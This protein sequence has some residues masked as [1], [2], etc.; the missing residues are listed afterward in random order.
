MS[1]DANQ[2]YEVHTTSYDPYMVVTGSGYTPV[3][4]SNVFMYS[5][6][7]SNNRK[8]RLLQDSQG[9]WR[10]QNLANGLYMT[11]G[12]STPANGVNVRQWTS[13]T[14]AIQYWSITEL[15]TVR[16]E[17]LSGCPVVEI[18]SYATSDAHTWMLDIESAMVSDNSNV[19]IARYSSTSKTQEF[20]LVPVPP[21]DNGYPTP[22]SVGWRRGGATGVPYATQGGN[23]ATNMCVGWLCPSTWIPSDSLGYERRVRVRRMDGTTSTWGAWGEWEAWS[24]VDPAMYEQYCYDTSAIDASFTYPTHKAVE[25]QAEVRAVAN[26]KHGPVAA[27]TMRAIYDPTATLT[28]GGATRGGL[29]VNVA[30][31]YTPATYTI[32]SLVVDGSEILGKATSI[33]CTNANSTLTIPWANLLDIPAE[34]A[35]A[36]VTYTR[37]TDLFA[38]FGG[39]RTATMTFSYGEQPED[40]P[41]FS[42]GDGRVLNATHPLG[43]DGV[44]MSSGNGVFSDADGKGIIYPFGAPYHVLVSITNGKLYYTTLS[45]TRMRPCHAFNWDGGSLL[46][47]LDTDP[48]VTDRTIKAD[49][50]AISLNKRQWQSV[51]FTDTLSSEYAVTGILRDGI[52]K[53]TR[54]SIVAMMKKHHVTYRS[55]SGE[56]A[57]VAVT[58]VSYSTQDTV[59]TVKVSVIQ[60]T[61]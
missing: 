48:L 14:N 33:Q 38:T 32:T 35:S 7:D 26:D 5:N 36:T 1:V 61:R 9:R 2:I 45:R 6:N 22:A 21:L 42:D 29:V 55:P 46:L 47:E 25:V 57:D 40:A 59:T 31:D 49:Y 18:G 43:V 52:T 50:E 3:A 24:A 39:T 58:D 28:S 19:K 30:T 16:Y 15:G 44:W 17:G 37:G 54:A 8:W 11:L 51:H 4:G 23:A 34:G 41:T 27:S 60:E 53:S 20:F 12:A 10:F 56:V 13:S